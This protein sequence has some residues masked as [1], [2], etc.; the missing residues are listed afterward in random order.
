MNIARTLT[1]VSAAIAAALVTS[2]SAHQDGSRR[3]FA[4]VKEEMQKVAAECNGGDSKSCGKLADIAKNDKDEYVRGMAVDSVTNQRVLADVAKNDKVWNVSQAAWNRMTDQSLLAEIAK[5]DENWKVRE[6]A[7]KRITDQSVLADVA[8]NDKEKQVSR[9]AVKRTTDPNVLADVA[10]NHENWLG[11]EEA[12]KRNTDQSVL[13]DIVRNDKNKGVREEAVKRITDQSVLADIVRNDKELGGVRGGGEEHC[14][15]PC[16]STV[17]I[18]S[19]P[20][21]VMMPASSISCATLCAGSAL[22]ACWPS[23]SASTI[24]NARLSTKCAPWSG[25]CIGT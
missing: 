1:F 25:N 7:V 2:C 3:P 10:K 21:S 22:S 15:A 9:A 24:R 17:S 6:E 19:W 20:S 18:S 8:K 16:W 14:W 13:A 11:R 23:W 5:N 12:V 4:D